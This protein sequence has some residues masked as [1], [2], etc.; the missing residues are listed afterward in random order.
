MP[1]IKH[2]LVVNTPATFAYAISNDVEQWPRFL[3]DYSS[4]TTI[5]VEGRKRYFRIQHAIGNEWTFWRITEPSLL[6]AYTE[7]YEPMLPFKYVHIIWTYVPNDESTEFIWDLE[8]E[9]ENG[10]ID[11]ENQ[12]TERLTSHTV[13]NHHKMKDFIEA[14]YQALGAP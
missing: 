7:R 14:Q 9:L 6:F 11:E 13:R 1:I 10:S 4:V 8:F 2:S 5:S 3:E 12:W